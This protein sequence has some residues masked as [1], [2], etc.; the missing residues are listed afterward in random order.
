MQTLWQ[1]LR[2]GLRILGKAPGF[3]TVAILSLALG[4]GASTAIFTLINALL[5]RELPV[6]QPEQLVELSV[7]RLE[8]QVPFSYPMFR[9]LERGQR[10]FSNLMAWSGGG[11][12]NVEV[13]GTLSQDTLVSVSGNYYSELGVSP[14][15][16]RLITPEDANA[17]S[18]S[19]SQ[20]AVLGYG[21]W[22]RRFG[23]ATDVVGRQIRIEGQSFTIVGVT[24]KWFTGMTPGEPPE[25]MIPV[26]AQPLI[27]GGS[28]QSL[29]DRS[30]L[31][32]S[33]TGRL[34]L[35][36]NIAQARAQLQSLWP[37]VLE[38]TASTQEPGLRR[39]RFLSMGLELAPAA[40]GLSKALRSEYT[41]PLYVLLGI[42]GLILLVACVNLANLMLARA[43]A[44]SQETSIRLALGASRWTLRR[45]VLTET[46]TLSCSGALLG[47]AFAYWG[48]HLLVSWMTHDSL[49]PIVFD[50][51][52]DWRVLCA[53][54]AAAIVTG[55][56]FGLAPAWHASRQDPACLLQLNARTLTTGVGMAGK[57]LIVTQ[58]ALSCVLVIGAGLLARTFQKLSSIDLGF[59]Q[60]NL[61]EVLLSAKPGGYQNVN[62]NA[63]HTQLLQRLSAIP[64]VR[65]VGMGPFVPAPEG[66]RDT[67]STTSAPDAAARSTGLMADATEVTPGFFA[68]MGMRLVRGRDFDWNDDD[69]HPPIAIVSRSLAERL[70]PDGSAIGR[71]IRFG[72]MPEYQALELVGVADDARLFDFRD[73]QKAANV[74][75]IPMLQDMKYAQA[76]S[77]VIR[78]S[79][80]PE[81][82]ARAVAQEIE[83]LGHEYALRTETVPQVMAQTLVAEQGTA[84]LS[85]FF[86]G[87]AL[88]LVSIGLYGLMSYAVSRRTHEIGIRVALGAQRAR[89]RW[90]VLREALML[91]VV[92]TAIGIPCALAAARLLASMLFGV[93]S[94]DLPTIMAAVALL[95]IVAA[96]AGYLPARRAMRVDPMVALRHT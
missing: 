15:L 74:V 32:L 42:V 84:A 11:L 85:A 62:V 58:V 39:Q 66:F 45:Q 13:N 19:T 80:S 34:K 2:Y 20:V 70:F 8:G 79:Q 12:H 51:R 26:T 28:I 57:V 46:L 64:G 50:L 75:Y 16:G 94:N 18:G 9:E 41:R 35:G 71:R 54:A 52:P 1:D 23:A 69:R 87:L 38:A 78:T 65:S 25:I 63:Y 73:A 24:R 22:Q 5:L 43:A 48:S 40:T 91:G 44:R 17:Q 14:L 3:T 4:I 55:I 31:W 68:T 60:D 10:V 7:R 33:L 83:S 27:S 77:L 89:V 47:L 6:R 36:V 76:E 29:D 90:M 49:A 88:L 82:V 21:F 59:Q 30:K 86:A 81:S 72:F 56:V 96:L 93:P 67:V 92:G 61:L 53:T 37:G 95:L